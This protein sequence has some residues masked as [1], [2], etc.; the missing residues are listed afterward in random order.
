MASDSKRST[1]RSFVADLI[2][3]DASDNPPWRKETDNLPCVTVSEM[4][5]EIV[6][7]QQEWTANKDNYDSNNVRCV[8]TKTG[9][10]FILYYKYLIAGG[11]PYP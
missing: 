6:Q 4:V 1:S 10:F 8:N 9:S 2:K 7:F 3:F 5:K 11:R